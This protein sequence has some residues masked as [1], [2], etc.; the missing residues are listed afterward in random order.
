MLSKIFSRLLQIYG[1][2]II[3]LSEVL[4]LQSPETDHVLYAKSRPG[5][6]KILRVINREWGRGMKP[7]DK[8]ELWRAMGAAG[9]IGFTLVA[10][11]VAGIWL[12][13]WVDRQLDSAPWATIGGIVLGMVAGVLGVYKQ[14]AEKK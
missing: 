4:P 10:S 8:R 6:N 2:Y 14:V 1:E 12:G 13:R 11:V 3:E 9:N 7:D 5:Y